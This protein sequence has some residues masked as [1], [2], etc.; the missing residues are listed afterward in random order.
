M[1]DGRLLSLM[2][3]DLERVIFEALPKSVDMRFGQTISGIEDKGDAVTVTLSG[4]AVE[5]VDLLMAQMASTHRCAPRRR[6]RKPVLALSRS[7]HRRLYL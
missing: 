5:T 6:R 2:R 4:G 7:P 3:G 1:L